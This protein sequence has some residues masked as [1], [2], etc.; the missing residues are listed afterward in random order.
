M[1]VPLHNT[2]L[3]V[4]CA[5][6][7]STQAPFWHAMPNALQFVPA[8]APWQLPDAPQKLTF[9]LGLTHVVPLHS[10]SPALHWVLEESSTQAP[11]WHFMPAAAQFSPRLAPWQSSDAPQ[12]YALLLGS[13]HVVSLQSTRPASHVILWHAPFWHVSPM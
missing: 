13:M 2:W 8:L 6:E 1:H 12:K 4:H 10:T 3:E 11:Y 7:P 5:E 9:V